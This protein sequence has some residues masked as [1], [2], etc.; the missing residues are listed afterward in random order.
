MG[1]AFVLSQSLI[2]MRIT[3]VRPAMLL[4]AK[5]VSRITPINA[6]LAKNNIPKLMIF[7]SIRHYAILM[8][9]ENA[10]VTPMFAYSVSILQHI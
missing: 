10:Q 6:L 9:V 1:A 2:L 7:V 8:G 4:I 3:N 5:F